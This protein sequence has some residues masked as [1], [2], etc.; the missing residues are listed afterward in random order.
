MIHPRSYIR[1]GRTT[2][3]GQPAN[4][5]PASLNAHLRMCRDVTTD[6]P[7]ESSAPAPDPLSADVAHGTQ[8]PSRIQPQRASHNL[9]PL[10]NATLKSSAAQT[11]DQP[12]ELLLRAR[13]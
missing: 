12:G 6:R 2:T 10:I 11:P 1:P 9:K 7:S 4:R 13:G 8:C 5:L 3:A